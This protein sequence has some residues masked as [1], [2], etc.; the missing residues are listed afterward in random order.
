MCETARKADFLRT[1]PEDAQSFWDTG[2]RQYEVSNSQHGKEKEHGC[3]KTV[4]LC[5]EVEK[6]T[7]THNGHKIDEAEGDADPDVVLLKS[8]DAQKGKGTHVVA[9]YVVYGH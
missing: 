6:D 2:G 1:K 8:R 9:S 7:I 4:L 3:M 5:N